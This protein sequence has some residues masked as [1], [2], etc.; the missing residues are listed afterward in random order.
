MRRAF[1]SVAALIACQLLLATSAS[2]WS[3]D[4]F[5]GGGD[6]VQPTLANSE[7]ELE[8]Q[9]DLPAGEPDVPFRDE[10]VVAEPVCAEWSDGSSGGVG[11]MSADEALALADEEREQEQ[12]LLDGSTFGK[13]SG[14]DSDKAEGAAAAGKATKRAA[15]QGVHEPNVDAVVELLES[16]RE[17]E[18]RPDPD[19]G[20]DADPDCLAYYECGGERI[21]DVHFGGLSDHADG[22]YAEYVG[23]YASGLDV[24][25]S[26]VRP[27]WEVI[28]DRDTLAAGIADGRLGA[29]PA[30]DAL[31]VFYYCR[32]GEGG[33]IELS[34]GGFEP[35]FAWATTIGEQYDLDTARVNS[36]ERLQTVLDGAGLEMETI[37]PIERGYT[38]VKLPMWLWLEN[39]EELEGFEV[40]AVSGQETVRLSTRATLVDVTWR[41]GDT[42]LV[43]GPGD[44]R[45]F[46]HGESAIT[47]PA[48]VCTHM[49]LEL[50]EYTIAATARYAIEERVAY[51]GSRNFEWPDPPWVPHPNTPFAEVGNETGPMQVHEIVS[52]NAPADF[53]P[54]DLEGVGIESGN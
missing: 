24:V 25:A 40:H 51:R 28:V 45:E 10:L 5:N 48:P 27:F 33:E 50:T 52:V 22:A 11:S 23:L 9:Q 41:I 35:S 4:P 17:D 34:E 16:T 14:K 39:I 46:V 32:I 47:D 13:E 36:L 44:M 38:F 19:G 29:Q 43:C 8:E 20:G 26:I 21:D 15:R 12:A 31:P 6:T 3:D 37:P 53:A 49:F 1:W 30:T 18:E 7:L 2:A 54:E 42:E